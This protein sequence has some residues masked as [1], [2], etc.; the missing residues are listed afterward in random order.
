MYFITGERFGF[1]KF[2]IV[3]VIHISTGENWKANHFELNKIC[4]LQLACWVQKT[5]NMHH[6][7]FDGK[8]KFLQ[9]HVARRMCNWRP[10]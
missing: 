2:K 10:I 1:L 3:P 9:F 8:R 7:N 4:F 6:E 5:L